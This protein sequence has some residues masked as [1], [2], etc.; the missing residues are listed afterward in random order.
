MNACECYL[1]AQL[2]DSGIRDLAAIRRQSV[3]YRLYDQ[4]TDETFSELDRI[5]DKKKAS[6][7][8]SCSSCN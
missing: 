1:D 6:C 8:G 2:Y 3:V 7:S 5:E 4:G